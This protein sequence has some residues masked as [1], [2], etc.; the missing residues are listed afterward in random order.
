[1]TLIA[2]HPWVM[3]K[4]KTSI[5]EFKVELFEDQISSRISRTS[6]DISDEASVPATSCAN[7]DVPIPANPQSPI[8]GT[9]RPDGNTSEFD[10]PRR[11]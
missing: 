10:A 9:V 4:F 5:G 8:A 7:S 3:A 2:S 6:P 11:L 1:M